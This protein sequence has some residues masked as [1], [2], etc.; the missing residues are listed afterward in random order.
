MWIFRYEFIFFCFFTPS[1]SACVCLPVLRA[2]SLAHA[3]RFEMGNLC[4][5]NSLIPINMLVIGLD[6][7]G[8]TTLLYKMR[9][10]K[11]NPSFEPTVAFNYEVISQ[12]YR[13]STF[14]ISTWDLSGG[15][16][17]RAVWPYFYDHIPF[18]V[19]MFVV[20]SCHRNRLKEAKVEY[21]RLIN[22]SKLLECTKV[23]INNVDS[24][25]L[26]NAI[27]ADELRSK[28]D[29]G[30]SV[31]IIDVNARTGDGVAAIYHYLY[32]KCVI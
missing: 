4:A 22:E 8:K 29:L 12:K 6:G 27:S 13:T 32:T 24:G 28:L 15:T 19:F 3:L 1:L 21:H 23:V 11:A 2:H 31:A 25:D 5:A 10:K 17:L 16:E 20:H 14:S 9:L 18:D 30:E 26:I 7:S